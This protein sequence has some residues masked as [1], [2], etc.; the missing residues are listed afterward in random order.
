MLMHGRSRMSKS[1]F[2]ELCI[3]CCLAME[4]LGGTPPHRWWSKAHDSLVGDAENGGG[5]CLAVCFGCVRMARIACSAEQEL[6]FAL[7]AFPA[8]RGP[9]PLLWAVI[10]V[11]GN[12]ARVETC[13]RRRLH[14][15][16][17]L[18]GPAASSGGVSFDADPTS[19]PQDAEKPPGLKI[20]I[21]VRWPG[22]LR[23]P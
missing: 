3:E 17:D 7:S 16:A 19:H 18:H 22:H 9:S 15:G 23:H 2:R 14:T 5:A 1:R 8:G 10:S 12:S 11:A 6:L 20:V 21:V 13:A 4:C